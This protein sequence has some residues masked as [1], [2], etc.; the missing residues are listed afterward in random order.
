MHFHSQLIALLFQ[1]ANQFFHF[2][3]N[4]VH[5]DILLGNA[6]VT[7]SDTPNTLSGGAI[8]VNLSFGGLAVMTICV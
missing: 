5:R 1:L 2:L 6:N 4:I 3:S 8:A 7:V